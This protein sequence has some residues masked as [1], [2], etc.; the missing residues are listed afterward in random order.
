MADYEIPNDLRYTRE[1]EWCRVEGSR[2]VVGVTDYAQQQL[3]D[4][5]FVELP[6]VGSTVERGEPFGVIESVKAVSDLYAPISGEV[7]E[8]NGDLADH[9]EHVNEDCYTDGWMITIEPSDPDEVGT[10]LDA[11]T[12]RTHVEERSTE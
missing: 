5:V 4:I 11:K 2:V 1:D 10:L 7:V 3:G 6:A 9:P 12:Y 8:V